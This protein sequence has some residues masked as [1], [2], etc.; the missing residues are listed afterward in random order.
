ML[1]VLDSLEAVTL[2]IYT[3]V[4]NWT[5]AE[6]QVLLAKVRQDLMDTKLHAQFD[7]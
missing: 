3:K 4:L 2:A 1:F 5:P 6:V 7:L